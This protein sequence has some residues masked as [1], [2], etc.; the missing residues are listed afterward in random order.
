MARG[1]TVRRRWWRWPLY[2][3][4]GLLVLLALLFVAL[5]TSFA[6]EQVRTRVNT[7]LAALFRGRIQ[8]ERVG[9]LTLSGVRGVDARIFDPEKRQVIRV[10]G[11]SASASLASLGWQFLVHPDQP[12]IDLALVHVDFADVTLR[13]DEDLGVTLATTFLLREIPAPTAALR[14]STAG[15]RLRIARAELDRIWAHGRVTGSPDLDA[16]L[17]K[18][19][20]SLRQSGEG[21]FGLELERVQLTTRALPLGA[22]PRGNVSGTIEVPKADTGPLRLEGALDGSAA[23]SPLALE[24]SWVGDYVH[25]AVKLPHLPSDF[26][27]R[28]SGLELNGDVA[29]AADVDG[30]LPQLDFQAEMLAVGARVTASGYAVVAQ[31]REL[32]VSAAATGV[33]LSRFSAGAPQSELGLQASALLFE[34]DER[35]LVGSHRVD[36][37][38][39]RVAGKSTPAI[40][41]AGKDRLDTD[42]GVSSSGK[43]GMTDPGASARG[44]YDISLPAGGRDS[45]KLSLEAKLEDPQR[46]A[47][48]GI[49]AAGTASLSAQLLPEQRTLTGHAAV[50]LRHLDYSVL[51]ARHVEAQA[52]VSGPLADPHLVAAATV[53]LLSGRAHADLDY[54]SNKQQLDVF[55]A[56]L[57]LPRL[58]QVAGLNIPIKQGKLGIDAHV[59]RHARAGSYRLDGTA[60]A[61][62]G[63]VGSLQVLANQFELPSSLPSC[64]KAE[65]THG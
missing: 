7:A 13:E 56:N 36:I 1:A 54:A 61:D 23:G 24:V 17:T 12:A 16:D 39:G 42:A 49:R 41:L 4:L 20:S 2:L 22:D 55:A 46:L 51:Q 21:G 53:D 47:A 64:A 34:A 40:W 9:E 57:D 60:S 19:V 6:R 65:A 58:S 52:Q 31:G 14:S 25:A 38:R 27:N 63:Q 44:G 15:P 43:F 62:L 26:V 11:L 10:Q 59:K 50:S 29:L 32:A 48:F 5:R 8:I 18:L 28:A 33:D 35:L 30:P 3:G 37:E 45:V